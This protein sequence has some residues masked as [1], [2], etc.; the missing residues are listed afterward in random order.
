M[1]SFIRRI[2]TVEVS[3]VCVELGQFC[4]AIL[5]ALECVRFVDNN[6][7]EH[8]RVDSTGGGE[9]DNESNGADDNARGFL[10]DN[11]ILPQSQHIDLIIFSKS[12]S[13]SAFLAV[14]LVLCP[15]LG[16]IIPPP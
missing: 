6:S 1:S 13:S 3:M 2:I 10:T 11:G 4:F 7:L 9:V 15:N 14:A 8:A 12:S 16:T 5:L